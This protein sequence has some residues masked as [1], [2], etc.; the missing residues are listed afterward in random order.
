MAR[1]MARTVDEIMNR[2]LLT[3]Q[4]ETPVGDVRD[5]F[6]AFGIG[7]VPVV[8]DDRR[9]LGVLSMRDVFQAESGAARDHMSKPAACIDIGATIDHAARQLARSDRHH[10]V[11]VDGAGLAAGMLS[12]LDVLR[13][14]LEM[15]TRHPSAFPHWDETTRV[16]WTDE[17]PLDDAS[18]GQAPD[19]PGF[20]LVLSG[21]FGQKDRV[22]WT[23]PCRSVRARVRELLSDPSTWSAASSP[24]ISQQNI[25]FRA[26]AVF[27]DDARQRITALLKDRFEHAPPPGAT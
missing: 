21:G 17:W 11:V 25:R 18:C 8:D 3:V 26:A 24:R 16:S 19:A 2:E 14:L 6:R 10:M 1:A 5:L 13:A 4:A 9:P 12:T 27:N 15:P 20:L 23:E 7:A 22:L